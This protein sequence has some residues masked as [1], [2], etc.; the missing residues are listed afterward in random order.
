MH[1][2]NLSERFFDMRESLTETRQQLFH[3]L[4]DVENAKKEAA[5]EAKVVRVLSVVFP[6][7]SPFFLKSEKA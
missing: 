7:L 1:R 4:K 6:P 5:S 2:Q 3:A